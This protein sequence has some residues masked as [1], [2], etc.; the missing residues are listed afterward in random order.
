MVDKTVRNPFTKAVIHNHIAVACYDANILLMAFS[1]QFQHVF[2]IQHAVIVS[3][4]SLERLFS[5]L[6]LPTKKQRGVT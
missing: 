6:K 1:F 4:E 5:V 2:D 3:I